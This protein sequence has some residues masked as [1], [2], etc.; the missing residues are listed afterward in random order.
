[1]FLPHL[2]FA[3]SQDDDDD[4]EE[5]G[6]ASLLGPPIQEDRADAAVVSV[7]GQGQL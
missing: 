4:E 6:T 5:L 3:S 7:E 2:L 1:M